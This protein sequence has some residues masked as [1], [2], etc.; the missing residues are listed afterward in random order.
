MVL[1]YY[2]LYWRDLDAFDASESFFVVLADPW[3]DPAVGD[4]LGAPVSGVDLLRRWNLFDYPDPDT[5][6]PARL[7]WR[8]R[9]PFTSSFCGNHFPVTTVQR[10]TIRRQCDAFLV[11]RRNRRRQLFHRN[12]CQHRDNYGGLFTERVHRAWEPRHHGT[13]RRRNP[14]S[15]CLGRGNRSPGSV[16]SPQRQRADRAKHEGIR[17]DA[18]DRQYSNFRETLLLPF[19]QPRVCVR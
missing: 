10:H 6:P 12:D 15:G 8:Y 4:C 2:Y 11:R 18:R 1:P 14:K 3:F 17:A 7:Q 9:L 5:R 19:G 13:A 16:H